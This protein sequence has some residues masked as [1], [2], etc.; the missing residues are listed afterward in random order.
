[1]FDDYKMEFAYPYDD[2]IDYYKEVRDEFLKRKYPSY[3]DWEMESFIISFTIGAAVKNAPILYTV[4]ETL[5]SEIY[6]IDKNYVTIQISSEKEF[7][8]LMEKILEVLA[9]VK[10][11][12]STVIEINEEQIEVKNEFGYFMDYI[13]C[14]NN[15]NRGYSK[16]TVSEVKQKYRK[17]KSPARKKEDIGVPVS[18]SRHDVEG[19][20]NSAIEKY[21]EI[22]G[23]NMLVEYY[24]ISELDKVIMIEDSLIVDFR[25]IPRYWAQE[26]DEEKR[27]WE[28]P[29]LIIQ[30]LTH[31]D[32]FKF[33]FAGYKR[34][35][36]KDYIG[37]DFL[38]FHGLNYYQKKVDNFEVVNN[39][40]PELQLL[41]RYKEYPGETHH[42]VILRMEDVEGKIV[43]GLGDTKG[44]VHAFILKL[45][46][47]LE[48]RNSRSLELNGASCLPYIKEN[49]DFVTAFLSWKGQKKRWRLENKFSY[50]YENRQIKNDSEIY[51]IQKK[52]LESSYKGEYNH[53]EFGSYSKPVNKW[54]SEELVY[55]I[56]K[57]IYKDYQ[58]IYQYKPYFLAT[59]KGCMSYD[60]YICGLKVAIEYQGK[61]HFEPVEFFGGEDNFKKQH[62]RD[63]LKAKLSKEN[64]VILVYVNY[65]EDITPNL[66]RSKID[67][68]LTE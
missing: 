39:N 51:R 28:Y 34:G 63:L 67:E 52:I 18:I 15:L 25:V 44:K 2:D 68:A 13:L 55:N 48:E 16:Y 60:I 20:L 22:Y 32:L 65:W 54:K 21:I 40:F 41:Q 14:K 8:E 1:M 64:G 35:F 23:R 61:Q 59:D 50:Y 46:K 7:I 27:D 9:I 47:E 36:E 53:M 19:A 5:P 58:V 17:R 37:I 3:P 42:F 4:L 38:A 43:Y 24:T 62:E 29:Y 66:V 49:M 6:D 12:K 26:D 56:T 30:E 10:N 11:W 31:N 33:N 45:C 57:K